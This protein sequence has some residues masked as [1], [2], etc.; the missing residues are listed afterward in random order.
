MEFARA[1]A[2]NVPMCGIVGYAGARQAVP[3]LLDGLKRLEYRGYDSAGVAV[4]SAGGISVSRTVGKLANLDALLTREPRSGSIGLGHTRWAT[5]G[6]PSEA[7]AHPHADCTG[8]I[9]LIHNGIIENYLPLKAALTDQGHV[10]R[11][12]TDT[13]VV[14]HLIEE[15]LKG[16]DLAAPRDVK[17]AEAALLQAV[18]AALTKVRGAYALA[19]IWTE[20][21]DVI[22]A[23][24][25]DSPLVI[26]LG[27]TENFMA[28]DVP[29][30]LKHTRMVVYLEDGE[31]AV[32]RGDGCTFFSS[33]G[34]EIQKPSTFIEWDS[35]AAEKAGYRHFMLK[36]I[37]EQPRA[38]EN[39]LRSRRL[40]NKDRAFEQE[41]GL[42]LDALRGASQV[43]LV[44]CGT[45]WHAALVGKYL[46]ERYAGI[47]AQVETASEFRYRK[48]VLAPGTLLISISQSGETADTLAAVRLAKQAGVKTLAIGNS[49]G[50]SIP[51][52]SDY[53]FHTYCGP[54]C[55]VASTKAFA[56]QLAALA[57]VTLRAGLARGWMTEAEGAEW[58]S[59]LQALPD[60]IRRTLKLDEQVREL[61][62]TFKNEERFLYIGRGVNYPTALEGALK[63]K[64]I[65]Y[66]HAEG[67]AAGE[68][69]HGP[70]ALIE[71]GTPVVAIATES[72][73]LEKTLS[74]VEEARARGARVIALCTEGERRLRGKA[75]R[76]LEL[77]PCPEFL[78][79]IVN[80]APLQ[81]LAYHIADLR[82]CDVDQ[83]RNLAKS[84]T[85]E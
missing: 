20:A 56:G 81:L 63:L 83:P 21:P 35:A 54:E 48:P 62:E 8:K 84:V 22:V 17:R 6:G 67:F 40:T 12:A 75:E 43:Q 29:P 15:E 26:G 58:T 61:A 3:I 14:A 53:N 33:L 28:S 11:S 59:E 82:G 18:R 79:P 76:V 51:R 44:A 80:A 10:F 2:Y 34:A 69:K 73:M 25:I 52:A 60:L 7:N 85:V 71:A 1:R 74:N 31:L 68:M 32:L 50:A 55:G 39:T 16:Y 36:E 78:S 24:K 13:E 5:H 42:T 27:Q 77:P 45:S 46:L 64:E 23:A 19:A 47:Q 41:T 37:H 66:I 38:V 70:L 49:V 9:A 57:I 72:E 4:V 65:S 30:L